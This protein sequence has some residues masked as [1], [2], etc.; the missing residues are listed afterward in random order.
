[1]TRIGA[2]PPNGARNR[3]TSPSAQMVNRQGID[4]RC[5]GGR[6]PRREQPLTEVGLEELCLDGLLM[7]VLANYC[8]AVTVEQQPL[9]LHR[10]LCDRRKKHLVSLIELGEEFLSAEHRAGR[11]VR[12]DARRGAD[13]DAGARDPNALPVGL[14]RRKRNGADRGAEAKVLRHLEPPY[15][16]LQRARRAQHAVRGIIYQHY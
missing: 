16:P 14:R 15:R 2:S 9:S 12:L 4:S 13:H 8:D 6:G 3:K 10:G 5:W 1:M 11:G 7:V